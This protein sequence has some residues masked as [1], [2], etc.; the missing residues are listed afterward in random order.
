MQ[1]SDVVYFS[2]VNLGVSDYLTFFLADSSAKY[3]KIQ[4]K[5]T[6]NIAPAGTFSGT[7]GM[8]STQW[9]NSQYLI[10]DPSKGMFTWDGN[11]TVSIGSVGVIAVTNPGSVYTTAPTVVISGPDQTGG[12]QANATASLVSGGNTVGSVVLVDGGAG[13]TNAANLTVTLN[14]GGGSGGINQGG[15]LGGSGTDI[16]SLGYGSGGGGGA[17]DTSRAAGNG[18]NYGAGGGGGHQRPAGQ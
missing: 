4:D 16:S 2:A 17:S 8:N 9:Y 11:N 14:G 13:Y 1:T 18:G 10:L 15:S 6:G 12:T 3:Y 7:S 5:S